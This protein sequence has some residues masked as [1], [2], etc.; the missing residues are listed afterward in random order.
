MEAGAAPGGVAEDSDEPHER[1]F[2][3]R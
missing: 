3:Q 2:I 1:R